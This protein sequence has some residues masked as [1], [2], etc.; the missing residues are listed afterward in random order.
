MISRKKIFIIV[1]RFNSK[2][3]SAIELNK[4]KTKL[5]LN[6]FNV[7]EKKMSEFIMINVN[8]K[9]GFV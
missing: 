3:T 4:S 1:K 6:I 7:I 2:D 8:L 9:N 5:K